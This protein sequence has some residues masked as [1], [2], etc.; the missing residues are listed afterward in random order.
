MNKKEKMIKL[1]NT[2]SDTMNDI[3]DLWD[4][5]MHDDGILDDILCRN[6]P[7]SLPEFNELTFNIMSL[8]SGSVEELR[9]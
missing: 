6:Y 2:L 4:D 3:C 8:C 7:I 5:D 9:K 1:L